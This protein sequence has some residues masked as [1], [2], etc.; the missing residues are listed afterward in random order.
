MYFKLGVIYHGLICYYFLVLY[1]D[2]LLFGLLVYLL[3]RV[4]GNIYILL[5]YSSSMV[6]AE[7]LIKFHEQ[8]CETARKLVAPKG[9]DYSAR[10]DEDTL[11]TLRLPASMGVSKSNLHTVMTIIIN[12]NGR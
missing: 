4:Q 5:F 1:M 3:L 12:K 7:Q 6:T 8:T 11:A 10:A 2:H 9:E